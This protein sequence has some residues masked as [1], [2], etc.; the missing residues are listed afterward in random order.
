[1]KSSFLAMLIVSLGLVSACSLTPTAEPITTYTLSVAN[2]GTANPSPLPV[3]LR[4][5]KPNASGYLASQRILVMTQAQQISLYKGAQW[6]ETLPL[7]VRNHLLDS[8]R[9]ANVFDYV[10]SDDKRL[11]ASVELDTDLR[12]FQAEYEQGVPV[13]H[14]QLVARL[15]DAN[16]KRILASRVFTHKQRASSADLTQVVASFSQAQQAMAQELMAWTEQTLKATA[17]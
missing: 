15:V 12:A 9:Q 14:L 8:F 5:N 17:K 11:M 13:V 1:M 10:S 7:L 16:Q 4:I 2:S 6:N 3:S